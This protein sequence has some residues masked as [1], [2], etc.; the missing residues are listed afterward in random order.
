MAKRKPKKISG[1][2]C[3]ATHTVE[4][5]G[6]LTLDLV[7]TLAQIAGYRFEIG[8]DGVERMYRAD[9][10]LARSANDPDEQA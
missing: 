8:A 10:T 4:V 3:R 7:K 9:G 1:I 5:S 6:P 2:D